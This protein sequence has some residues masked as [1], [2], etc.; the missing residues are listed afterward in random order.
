[1]GLTV[2]VSC[3]IMMGLSLLAAVL[4][5]LV[6]FLIL[7]KKYGCRPMPFV[8]GMV[9]MFVFAFTLEQVFHMAVLY[10]SIGPAITGNIWLYGLYGG[11]AAGIFEETG[12][13]VAFK[14]ILKKYRADDRTALMYGAGH[15]GFEAMYILGLG[16]ISNLSLAI[17]M[18]TG[19]TEILFA[20]LPATE[21]ATVQATL[22]TLAE[23]PA[24]LYLVGIVERLA[25][26]VAHLSLSVFV[27]FAVKRNF[28]LF[29]IA[30]LMHAFLDFSVVVVNSLL[31]NTLVTELLCWVIALVFAFS[32]YK[33]WKKEKEKSL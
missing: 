10:S 32:A 27:W 15:G 6:L 22:I 33:L 5:P 28:L 26:V 30:I 19:G 11:L 9:I 7:W 31:A 4:I 12:R 20:G 23:T 2:P 29:P 1:M 14:W 25:A 21:T 8:V 17:L 13:F 16:M 3:V 18:N 24:P